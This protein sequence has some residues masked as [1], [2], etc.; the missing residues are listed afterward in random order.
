VLP[1]TGSAELVTV[2]CTSLLIVWIAV[3]TVFFV[4]ADYY[5]YFLM[6]TGTSFPGA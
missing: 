1:V 6:P 2:L 3:T 5:Y 4:V